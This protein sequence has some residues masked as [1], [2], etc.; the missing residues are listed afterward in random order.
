VL[1]LLM[2]CVGS[3]YVAPLL[4]PT[5]HAISHSYRAVDTKMVDIWPVLNEIHREMLPVH[6]DWVGGMKLQ[7]TN[8][9]GIRVNRN[10]SA[11]ALHYDKVSAA[12]LYSSV[13]LESCRSS[14]GGLTSNL[15]LA[16]A[17]T[18]CLEIYVLHGV[19]PDC[20]TMVSVCGFSD[21]S[22]FTACCQVHTHV[23]SS[24]IHIDH[25]YFDDD[26]A[27]PI[28]IE[29]HDGELHSLLLEPGQVR[30]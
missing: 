23:I 7:P 15:V 9:Y 14:F 21:P 29:D 2:L 17:W 3:R 12:V 27:W 22:L 8:I 28:E 25:E 19:D 30:A 11:L 1:F 18:R 20:G 10:G 13:N 24:I 6:E 5:P 4:I 26:E 16:Y